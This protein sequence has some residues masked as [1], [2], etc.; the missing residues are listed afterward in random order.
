MY[1]YLYTIITP[2]AVFTLLTLT[3]GC[4]ND[5]TEPAPVMIAAGQTTIPLDAFTLRAPPDNGENS[6]CGSSDADLHPCPPTVIDVCD[7]VQNATSLAIVEVIEQTDFVRVSGDPCAKP[8]GSNEAYI[9]RTRVL[10]VA[11]GE[12][13]PA[14]LRVVFLNFDW[15]VRERGPLLIQLVH[16]EGEWFGT[17]VATV[18]RDG[19]QLNPRA[20][21]SDAA[22]VY[23]IPDNF[24][25][26]SAEAMKKLD[27]YSRE[28]PNNAP[29]AT[30]EEIIH[31]Y[32]HFYC[33]YHPGGEPA[34]DDAGLEADAN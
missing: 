27:N 14:E 34:G 11:A 7:W 4:R 30:E 10:A 3:N 12:E 15:P 2:M 16:L 33:D 5:A 9:V 21:Q 26:L 8:Y 13:L 18:M 29:L 1:R 22:I 25:D 19:E 23:E 20:P 24:T 28:C 31:A 32:K 17:E 6:A